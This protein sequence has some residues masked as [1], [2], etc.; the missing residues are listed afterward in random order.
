MVAHANA[1]QLRKETGRR[2]EYVSYAHLDFVVNHRHRDASPK[3]IWID[4][5]FRAGTQI[6]ASERTTDEHERANANCHA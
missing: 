6:G 3:P 4:H 1:S 2:V 5:P